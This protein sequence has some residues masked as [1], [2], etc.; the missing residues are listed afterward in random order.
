MIVCLAGLGGRALG[1]VLGI[2]ACH[3][4]DAYLVG[5]EPGHEG[6]ASGAAAG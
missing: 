5:V 6:G 1:G 2:F 4:T 3:V